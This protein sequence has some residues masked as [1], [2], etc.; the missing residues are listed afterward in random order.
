MAGPAFLLAVTY[1]CG[2]ATGLV[3]FI[4]AI[5]NWGQGHNR[6]TPIEDRDTTRLCVPSLDWNTLFVS[7]SFVGVKRCVSFRDWPKAFWIWYNGIA[8]IELFR[9]RAIIDATSILLEG[10]NHTR[11]VLQ[12]KIPSFYFQTQN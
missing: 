1:L 9:G 8:K 4:E 10:E 2:G 5:T 3:F 12:I 11:A 6:F 7:L